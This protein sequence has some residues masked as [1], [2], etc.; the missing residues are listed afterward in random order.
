[1][2][3]LDRRLEAET[4]RNPPS[5]PYS[6]LKTV[7]VIPLFKAS[8]IVDYNGIWAGWGFALVRSGY[9]AHGFALLLI[10]YVWVFSIYRIRYYCT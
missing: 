8:K 2:A 5:F 7:E 4:D 6:I 9:T 1:M 10:L 3:Q